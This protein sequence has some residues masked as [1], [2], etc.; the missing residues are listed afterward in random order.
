M[1]DIVAL[2]KFT[3]WGRTLK[4]ILDDHAT[5]LFESGPDWRNLRADL[6]NT[7]IQDLDLSGINFSGARLF[8]CTFQNC[9]LTDCCFRGAE[10]SYCRFED[11]TLDNCNFNDANESYTGSS[12]FTR[13]NMR[14]ARFGHSKLSF[15]ILDCNLSGSRFSG[16]TFAG[17]W[18]KG[19]HSVQFDNCKF[20]YCEFNSCRF[21]DCDFR[22]ALFSSC[23]YADVVL[24][25]CEN[26]DNL[27]AKMACPAE[28][29]FVG[30]KKLKNGIIA[31]LKIPAKAKRSS[32]LG[33]KC[34][35]SEAKVLRLETID[36]TKLPKE[37]I[38]FS[39]YDMTFTYEVGKTVVP[40]KP[41]ETYRYAECAPGI[42]FFMNRI[43]AENY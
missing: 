3:C 26:A 4:D 8:N 13:C 39:T 27:N 31:V 15:S 6:A 20:Y 28:G 17:A 12:V 2:E 14:G 24:D 19:C 18:F 9:N 23:N 29:S 33:N 22:L 32:A 25:E 30:Y 40:T 34:R 1:A 41:F 37:T 35:C 7:I 38:G 11:C 21:E 10:M 42:H 43:D 16:V 5:W 36:G